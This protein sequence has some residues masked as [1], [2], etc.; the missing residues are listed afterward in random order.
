MAKVA[1]I[2]KA[3]RERM[4]AKCDRII[5][6]GCNV[7]I[8]RLLI[9]NLPE[10]HFASHGIMAIEH[11]DFD[12]IER[13]AA[14]T[15]GEIIATFDTP[16]AIKLGYCKLI[17]EVMIG[18]ERVI[19]FSG[20]QEG[21]ACSV[22]LRGS[23]SHILEEAER[24]LH[25]ALCVLSETMK[26]TRIVFGG[27][28]SET[29]MAKVVDELAQR[30]PGKKALAMEAFARALR[31]IP[32]II[33]DNAGFDAAELVSQLRAAHAA[34][35]KLA[36]IDVRTGIVGNMVD[37]GITESFKV[38]LQVLLSASEAA[39]MILRCDEIIQ[40][41]PRPRSRDPRMRGH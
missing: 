12:G 21:E 40:Q 4:T 20:T 7:F 31:Q 22:I 39:E 35:D 13:L 34:G 32:T 19:R 10:Q 23:S 18:E 37:L 17:E 26:E 3:E 36:G 41:P 38:K 16:G 5:A 27:G 28:C 14:V 29:L 15:G 25:D 9:Y 30:T 8:N 24:S 2:E 6:Y 1:E 33:C 11:A